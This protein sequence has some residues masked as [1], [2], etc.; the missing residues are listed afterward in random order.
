[1]FNGVLVFDKNIS[2]WNISSIEDMTN[3]FK[4]V[5]ISTKNYDALLKGWSVQEVENNVTFDAGV[6]K[7]SVTVQA[8]RDTLTNSPN[9]WNITDGGQE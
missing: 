7:Y 5:N 8:N 4:D 2:D 6:S 9:D 3:M 1:M